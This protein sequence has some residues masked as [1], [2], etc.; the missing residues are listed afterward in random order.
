MA[1]VVG[2][3][4]KVMLVDDDALQLKLNA[5]ILSSEGFEVVSVVDAGHALNEARA[6]RPDLIVSDVLMGELDGFGLCRAVKEDEDLSGIPVLLLSAVFGGANNIELATRV[7]ARAL[8]ERSVGFEREL[9]AVRACLSSEA[10]NELGRSEYEERLELRAKKAEQALAQAQKMDALGRL[11]GGIAHDFNNLLAVIMTHAYFLQEELAEQ[12]PR[13][14]DVVEI[15]AAGE[16]AAGLTKQLLAFSRKQHVQLKSVDVNETIHNLARMLQRLLGE[17]MKLEIKAGEVGVVHADASQ[18]EQVILNLVVNARDAMPMGGMVSVETSRVVTVD[19]DEIGAGEWV[20]VSV[21]DAGCG[22]SDETKKRL[23]EPF[24]TTKE[25]GKGTGLGLSTSY[26][27]VKQ[28]GGHILVE[29]EMGQGTVM[30]VLLPMVR[31]ES[32]GTP[33]RSQA[34]DKKCG[35]ET[36]LLVEDDRAVRAALLRVLVERGYDVLAAG[37]LDEAIEVVRKHERAVQLIV[38]DVVMP[39]ARGPEA[40]ERLVAE[41]PAAKVLLM[42]GYTDHVCLDEVTVES[43]GFIQKPFAPDAFSQKVRDVL[44]R[45]AGL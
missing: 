7:G 26:G 19:G 32:L 35:S 9:A 23:F 45:E 6:S 20:G 43:Q 41:A 1:A 40:V 12:D 5:M 30:K 3:R 16:R 24:F 25:K 15:A 37:G 36:V 14:Q 21:R 11:T 22:M 34:S 27:I 10:C 29:S 18:L 38:C 8:V 17:E 31:G 2:G 28:F 13:Y 33:A 44:A 42:S 4:V 39:G